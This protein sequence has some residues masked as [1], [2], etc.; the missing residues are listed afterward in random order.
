MTENA[1]LKATVNRVEKVITKL[2]T[3]MAQ[4]EEQLNQNSKNSS[5]SPSTNQKV[6]YSLLPQAENRPYRSGASPILRNASF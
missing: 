1:E 5:K 3:R 2:E 6:N 4:L